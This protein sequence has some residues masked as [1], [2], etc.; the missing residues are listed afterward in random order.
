MVPRRETDTEKFEAFLAALCET[1]TDKARREPFASADDFETAIRATINGRGGYDGKIVDLEPKPQVFPD[2]DLT[3]FGIEVKF[4]QK[5][6]WRSIANSVF[7]GTRTK[8]ITEIYV[9]FG[10]MGGMPEVRWSRYEDAVMHV[11]TSHVPRFELEIGTSRSL[12]DQFGIGYSAFRVLP[13]SERMDHV[14]AYARGRLKPGERLWWI[15]DD[16]EAGSHSLPLEVRLYMNLSQPEKRQLRAEGALL[17]PQICSGSRVRNKYNDVVIYLLTRHG[18]FCPQAR[19][20]FSAGSVAQHSHPEWGPNYTARALADIEDEM[21]SAAQALDDALFVEYWGDSC[22]PD[23]RIADWLR[24][25]DG[26]A[27]GW[28]PSEMLFQA[29]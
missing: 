11:R 6:T 24:R 10:K 28:T 3:P 19:D 22:P 12:F 18:V 15:E 17:C 16:Q 7:E 20:L 14:R 13:L 8:D 9:V 26:F 4:S 29:R 27:K 5:D 1:L 2:I 21:R 25:A 23:R